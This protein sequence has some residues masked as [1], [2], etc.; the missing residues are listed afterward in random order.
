MLTHP[1]LKDRRLWLTLLGLIAVG[2]AVAFGRSYLD[3]IKVQRAAREALTATEFNAKVHNVL[4]NSPSA[5][6]VMLIVDGKFETFICEEYDL[7]GRLVEGQ[8]FS[9]T[10]IQPEQ[11]PIIGPARRKIIDVNLPKTE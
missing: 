5:Y 4:S 9:I 7:Q 10:A 8:T 1:T 6:S 2:L 11:G 3:E